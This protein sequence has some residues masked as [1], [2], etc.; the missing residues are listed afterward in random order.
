MNLRLKLFTSAVLFSLFTIFFSN[1]I[2]AD[3]ITISANKDNFPA[4]YVRD[5]G[6][7]GMDID[8]LKEVLVR[9]NLE[10]RI[11]ARPFKRSLAQMRTGTI[12]IMPNLVNSKERSAYMHW[13]GP[14]RITGIGLVVL[15][16]DQHLPI[17]TCD[18]L[19]KVAHQKKKKFGYLTG[20]SYSDYF[21]NRLKNDSSL[22]KVIHYTVTTDQNI[23][24]LQAGRTI[25][26]FYD[27]F[28][29]QNLIKDQ[30]K[31]RNKRY[32]GLVLNSYRIEDSVGGA[33]TG[34][35]KKLDKTR[36]QKIMTAYQ[37]M[38]D[39]GTLEKIHLKWVGHKPDFEF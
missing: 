38:I 5:K 24:M 25:G 36:Y 19:I 11:V 16:K 32:E 12:H 6:W 3:I 7:E 1:T 14:I 35:S 31:N 29:I 30:L 10:Y 33:Y 39:D 4:T 34:I 13:L 37:S 21:D 20:A 9:A 23:D 15:E 28:E 18:D 26:F 17:K 2:F 8:V 27:D 22:K